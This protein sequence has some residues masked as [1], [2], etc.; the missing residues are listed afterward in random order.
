MQDIYIEQIDNELRI[1]FNFD[2]KTIN[3]VKR[4]KGAK[5]NSEEKYWKV[6]YTR[7]T[8]SKL[9]TDFFDY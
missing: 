1:R 6:P 5:W 9:K 2:W 3:N 8:I 4:I 7:E